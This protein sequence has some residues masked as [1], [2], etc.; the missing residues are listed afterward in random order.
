MISRRAGFRLLASRT[1]VEC[2][3]PGSTTWWPFGRYGRSS[4]VATCGGVAKSSSPPIRSVSTFEVRMRL[5]SS[6]SGAGR[7]GVGQPAAAPGERRSGI[8]EDRV[9]AARRTRSTRCAAWASGIAAAATG[10]RRTTS[11]TR[12][13]R[14]ATG[15]RTRSRRRRPPRATSRASSGAVSGAA[16]ERRLHEPVEGGDPHVALLDRQERASGRGCPP[17]S[18]ASTRRGR[19]SACCSVSSFAQRSA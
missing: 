1:L 5:Y 13:R 10:P 8:A 2:P 11:G 19:R 3:N 4:F 16:S 17:R 7:P 15:T 14:G 9:A 12:G 18:A 6:S